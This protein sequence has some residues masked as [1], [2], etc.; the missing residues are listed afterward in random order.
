MS[1]PTVSVTIAQWGKTGFTARCIGALRESDYAGDIEILVRDNAS[2]GGPGAVSDFADIT[3]VAGDRNIGFGPAH[4]Q[5]A[6]MASGELL[7]I[8]N[9]DTVVTPS[10]IGRLVETLTADRGIGAVGPRYLDFLGTTLEMGGFVGSGASAWQFLRGSTAP[11]TFTT[12]PFDADYVSGACLL[13]DRRTFLDMGGFDDAYAPAYYEDTDLCFR[14]TDGGHRIVVEPRALVYHY[15]GA[16]AGRDV[17]AGAKQLQLTH[18]S[19]FAERWSHR[20]AGAPVASADLALTKALGLGDRPSVLW[21]APELPRPDR[22][23]GSARLV[24]ML[25]SLRSAGTAVVLWVESAPEWERYGPLLDGIGVPYLFGTSALRRP[26]GGDPL[27][28][29][30]DRLARLHPWSTV[31]ISFPEMADR[32]L[33]AIREWVPGR[34][35]VVDAVD[36]HYLRESRSGTKTDAEM[37]QDKRWEL[38]VYRAADAVVTASAEEAAILSA[39]LPESPARAFESVPTLEHANASLGSPT[40]PLVFLGNMNHPPN[41]AAVEYWASEIAPL[42]PNRPR[43]LVFGAASDRI[44]DRWESIEVGGWVPDL[45]DAFRGAGVFAAPLTYGAGTKGKILEAAAAGVPIVTTSI[46]AE[47]FGG[48]L[49]DALTV[50]DDP[51]EFAAEIERLLGDEIAWQKQADLVLRGFLEWDEAVAARQEEWARWMLRRPALG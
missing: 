24:A 37:D 8:L 21:L 34:P 13:M 28:V 16:T 32:F 23:A 43:L 20:L 18:Q 45:R 51:G 41:E 46:G 38:G 19:V 35:V 15:E 26:P 1:L 25:R 30:I 3:L 44:E 14:L 49:L 17:S 29:P 48:S 47:G 11:P 7:L 31:A 42:L 40:G 39:E 9:N 5:L 22:E 4:D 50:T 6:E 2:D 27:G 12:R 33:D 10:A 36:L